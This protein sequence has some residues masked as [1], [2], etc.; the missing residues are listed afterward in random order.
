[1][2]L[3]ALSKL[4]FVPVLIDTSIG[5]VATSFT[6]ENEELVTTLAYFHTSLAL[7][8]RIC[9]TADG[10]QLVLNSGLFDAVNDSRLFSTDPDIGL[11][12][13]NPEALKEFYRL[14]SSVL[15][16]ITA[17]VVSKGPSNANTIQQ[18]QKFLQRNRFSIQAVFKRISAVYKTSGPPETEA[19]EVADEFA[20]LMLVT[21]F[22]EEDE[23]TQQRDVRTNGFT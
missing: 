7:L 8:L 3:R 9:Q 10:A 19:M 22:L 2:I 1:V 14:L 18:A 11:D 6:V 5:S 4:N 20:R 16:V 15:R 23:S 17:L 13:D 21:G 12:I